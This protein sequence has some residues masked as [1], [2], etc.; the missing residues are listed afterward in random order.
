MVIQT[1]VIEIAHVAAAAVWALWATR[2]FHHA[3]KVW[4]DKLIDDP[5]LRKIALRRVRQ[6]G[7]HVLTAAIITVSGVITM[8]YPIGEEQSVIRVFT[9]VVISLQG[10]YRSIIEHFEQRSIDNPSEQRDLRETA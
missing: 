3:Y 7:A 8:F 1:E 10:L 5:I 4:S 9:V 2:A 6:Q